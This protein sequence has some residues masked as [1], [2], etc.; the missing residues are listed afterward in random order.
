[1]N[2][3]INH[4]D[5]LRCAE[6]ALGVLDASERRALEQAANADPRLQRALAQWQDRLACLAE[7]VAPVEPTA[8]VWQRIQRDLNFDVA[9]PDAP[10]RRVSLWDSV[11][12]WRWVGLAASAAVLALVAV[13]MSSLIFPPTQQVATT[14]TY[15]VAA[16]ARQDGVTQWT[17]TVDLRRSNMVVVPIETPVVAAGHTTELWLIPH[18]GKPIALGVFPSNQPASMPIPAEILAQMD[19]KAV[20]AVSQEPPGGSPTGLPTGPVLASGAIRGA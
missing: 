18:N 4:D 15:R 3:P 11:R 8:R 1:M 17:A 2:S 20:L 14:G 19:D 16:M 5:D 10:E 7:D 9:A 12:L 6:Y 13:N